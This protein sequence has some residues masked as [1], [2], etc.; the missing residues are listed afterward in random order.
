MGHH[1][2]KSLWNLDQDLPRASPSRCNGYT[3]AKR[4]A[5]KIGQ[6]GTA[7]SVR[8]VCYEYRLA[9]SGG[10]YKPS[11][12]A[13]SYMS[14]AGASSVTSA[15]EEWRWLDQ[16]T[17][18]A[19]S[20]GCFTSGPHPS[21]QSFEKDHDC[22]NWFCIAACS[23]CRSKLFVGSTVPQAM[24]EPRGPEQGFA[25]PGQGPCCSHLQPA[26]PA[27]FFPN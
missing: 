21:S 12:Q 6:I 4:R 3:T 13:S 14:A 22:G 15:P 10:V 27:L 20:A 8:C 16:N 2:M 11:Q 5:K 9:S 7:L 18:Y 26:G 23:G 17:L 1:S 19:F 25:G 24:V